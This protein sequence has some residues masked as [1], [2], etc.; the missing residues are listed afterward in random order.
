MTTYPRSA[1]SLFATA[2]RETATTQ[3]SVYVPTAW[4]YC[5]RCMYRTDQALVRYECGDAVNSGA[6]VYACPCGR[7]N[8]SVKP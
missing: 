4:M 8:R 3:A 5:S 6:A 1:A 2:A 7:E